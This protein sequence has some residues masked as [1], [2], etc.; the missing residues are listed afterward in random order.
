MTAEVDWVPAEMTL[1]RVVDEYVMSRNH[2][3]F[4]VLEG[5]R[6]LGLLCL[7]DIRAVARESWGHVTAREAVPPLAERHVIAPSAD[8][9][10]ALVRMTAGNCGRLLVMEGEALRGI[11]SRTDIMRLM[12]TRLELGV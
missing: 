9:W 4:P 5:N 2:P 11:I 8:A 10:D 3:A 6:V 7:S 12:R 1:D